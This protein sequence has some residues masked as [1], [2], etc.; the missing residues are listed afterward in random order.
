MTGTGCTRS[1]S[2]SEAASASG[3]RPLSRGCPAARTSGRARSSP[4][5]VP[6]CGSRTAS[7]RGATR[8]AAR[9]RAAPISATVIATAP[10]VQRSAVASRR[11]RPRRAPPARPAGR[12]LEPVGLRAQAAEAGRL[13]DQ[14]F[15][16]ASTARRRVVSEKTGAGERT[17]RKGPIRSRCVRRPGEGSH[18][19]ASTRAGSERQVQRSAPRCPPRS[20]SVKRHHGPDDSE[21]GTSW[22]GGRG[23]RSYST[24]PMIHGANSSSPT[25]ASS[26]LLRLPDAT[27][28]ISSKI[29]RP[30]TSSG[31]PSRMTP[32]LMSMSSS[33]W[34]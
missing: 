12:S 27:A 20:G 4:A 2:A 14:P 15:D 26:L 6:A 5:A 7:R 10:S 24:G 30:T 16:G 29:C 32:A 28:I 11:F 9:R 1:G 23:P 3:G 19:A 33:M 17:A 22:Q 8:G 13:E 34:R 25:P 21:H 18:P 31:V